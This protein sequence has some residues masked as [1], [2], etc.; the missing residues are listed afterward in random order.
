MGE[1]ILPIP[2]PDIHFYNTTE[3]TPIFPLLLFVK[4]LFD[5]QRFKANLRHKQIR[6][7]IQC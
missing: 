2:S 3:T 1:I 6:I 5:R 7:Q 4:F